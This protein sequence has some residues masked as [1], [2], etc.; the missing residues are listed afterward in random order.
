MKALTKILLLILATSCL[1]ANVDRILRNKLTKSR[2]SYSSNY[3][4]RLISKSHG[5]AKRYYKK[6]TVSGLNSLMKTKDTFEYK[7]GF[8]K[9]STTFYPYKN[10]GSLRWGTKYELYGYEKKIVSGKVS[11]SS[12]QAFLGERKGNDVELLSTYGIAA[13]STKQMYNSKRY[14]SCRRILFIKKCKWKTKNIPRGYTTGEISQIHNYLQYAAHNYAIDKLPTSFTFS[15]SDFEIERSPIL[16]SSPFV[17][18]REILYG[19]NRKDVMSSVA[20]MIGKSI[21]EYAGGFNAAFARGGTV[22]INKGG[23]YTVTLNVVGSQ[24]DVT[25]KR[26]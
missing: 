4:K 1:C 23:K 18:G 8:F 22:K 7:G 17:A 10:F 25:V 3:Q 9:K 2:P 12:V 20:Y 6:T 24:Y 19:V 15:E 16:A 13:G 14:R 26:G 11:Y 5:T 21:N